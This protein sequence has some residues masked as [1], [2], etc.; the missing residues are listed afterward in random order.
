MGDPIVARPVPPDVM[1]IGFV[2]VRL[3][4]VRLSTFAFS[5]VTLPIF[6]F[7][8]TVKS[9]LQRVFL[10]TVNEFAIISNAFVVDL[11]LEQL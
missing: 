3:L 5:S 8:R 2:A 1:G 7:P 4:T 10:F 11:P 9:P 6:V